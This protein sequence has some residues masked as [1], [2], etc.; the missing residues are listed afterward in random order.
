MGRAVRQD[1]WQTELKRGC[2]AAENVTSRRPSR[3]RARARCVCIARAHTQGGKI[4]AHARHAARRSAHVLLRRRPFPEPAAGAEAP[5]LGRLTE[6]LQ[7]FRTT[8]PVAELGSAGFDDTPPTSKRVTKEGFRICCLESRET[9]T[10]KSSW[11]GVRRRVPQP[12]PTTAAS[13]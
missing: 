7:S 1:T 8:C 13:L 5:S 11:G 6:L 12:C 3:T 4:A 2:A 9:S 10:P